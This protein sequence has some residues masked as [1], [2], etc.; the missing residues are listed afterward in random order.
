MTTKQLPLSQETLAQFNQA[1]ALEPGGASRKRAGSISTRRSSQSGDL[2]HT[3]PLL[4]LR[5]AESSRPTA[6]SC[7]SSVFSNLNSPFARRESFPMGR[8]LSMGPWMHCGRVSFSGLPLHQPVPE[9]QFENTYK[10]KPDEGCH[11][12]SAK[13]QGLLEATLDSYLG[14]SGYSPVT[15]GQLSQNLS[16]LIRSKAKDI[17]PP[18]YKLVCLVILGQCNDQGVQVASRCLWDTES[19]NFAVAT[20]QNSS[21]F[22][23]AS[24]YGLYCE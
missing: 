23:V 3:K 11:F 16:D 13:F 14:E 9:I 5:N 2:H 21:I 4:L 7:R 18:R 1:L 24:V 22:A 10:T 17:T 19:D 6:P 15:C 20:V 8:R 12:N